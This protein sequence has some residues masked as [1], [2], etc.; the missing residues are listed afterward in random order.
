MKEKFDSHP[1]EDI[2]PTSSLMG[3][4]ICLHFK[5]KNLQIWEA[6][7]ALSGLFIMFKFI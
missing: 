2:N 4:A 5:Q 3:T 1:D 7:K 6:K